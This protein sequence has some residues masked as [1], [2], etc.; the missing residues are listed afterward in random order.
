MHTQTKDAEGFSS[1]DGVGSA[2]SVKARTLKACAQPK[3]VTYHSAAIFAAIL[4]N[5]RLF[6]FQ[7]DCGTRCNIIRTTVISSNLRLGK[8]DQLQVMENKSSEASWQ[9]QAAAESCTK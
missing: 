9:E 4:L 8:C 2:I 7:L 6:F 1:E 5:E 3:S